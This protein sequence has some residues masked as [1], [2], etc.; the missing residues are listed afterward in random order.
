MSSGDATVGSSD[1]PVVFETSDEGF[2]EGLVPEDAAAAADAKAEAPAEEIDTSAWDIKKAHAT[3]KGVSQSVGAPLRLRSEYESREDGSLNPRERVAR[4]EAQMNELMADLDAAHAAAKTKIASEEDLPEVIALSKQVRFFQQQLQ[5]AKLDKALNETA[6]LGDLRNMQTDLS[7]KLLGEIASFK[8]GEAKPT[9]AAGAGAGSSAGAS[10]AAAAGAVT[11]ELYY[12]PEHA[13]F[14]QA[15]KF[16]ELE[17]RLARLEQ[18]IGGD[19]LESVSSNLALQNMSLVS[20]VNSLTAR[21][22]AVSEE[23]LA[24][25]D[26]R[27]TSILSQLDMARKKPTVPE[28]QAEYTAKVNEL[29]ELGKRWD[30]TAAVVPEV[31]ERLKVLKAL[32]EKGSEFGKT[33]L[34]M[35]TVQEQIK[36]T[37]A[38]QKSSLSA[39]ESSFAQNLAII[40]NNFKAM[41]K[42]IADLNANVAKLH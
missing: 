14:N 10:A 5:Q 7:R 26:R 15:V 6:S 29:Y 9:A 3:F 35:E 39:V 16:S 12:R 41:E 32:H 24:D 27:L 34:H 1:L 31:V 36:S 23:N 17:Q 42:R 37:L 18:Q 8:T 33:L 28:Q 38:T 4:L 13:N 40:E 11:Y 19:S 21:L 25:L 20:A 22:N 2:R 30:T